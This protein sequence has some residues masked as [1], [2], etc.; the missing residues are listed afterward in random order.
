MA[1][2]IITD[3]SNQSKRTERYPILLSWNLVFDYFVQPGYN[4]EECIHQKHI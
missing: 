2:N 1:V 4:N 3:K